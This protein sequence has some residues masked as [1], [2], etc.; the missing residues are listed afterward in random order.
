[1]RRWGHVVG[2]TTIVTGVCVS[3]CA[4]IVSLDSIAAN[5]DG[6]TSTSSEDP[7]GTS[8]SGSSGK[9]STSSGGTTSSGDPSSSSGATTSSTSSS[10]GGT[11]TV[12]AGDVNP[13]VDAGPSDPQQ[14]CNSS[15][16]CSVNEHNKVCKQDN[17]CATGCV[18]EGQQY[19]CDPF[20]QNKCCA[21]F[22]CV[23]QG[24]FPLVQ[25]VCVKD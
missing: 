22:H 17:T 21:G 24:R 12:D 7:D 19:A 6:G 16:D 11:G 4:S 5:A 9:S 10:T 3:A 20:K 2:A 14:S 23:V 15:T 18:S 1:M 8:S 25:D 13:T